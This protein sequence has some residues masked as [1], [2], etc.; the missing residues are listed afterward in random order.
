MYKHKDSDVFKNGGTQV[1][2]KTDSDKTN[3]NAMEK[4]SERGEER[5]VEI[6]PAKKIRGAEK[7]C[8]YTLYF[9]LKVLKDLNNVKTS[10]TI[11]NRGF[12]NYTF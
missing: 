11:K 2:H 8:S 6:V 9:K 3:A 5:E 4:T 7:R 10:T 1:N 12:E